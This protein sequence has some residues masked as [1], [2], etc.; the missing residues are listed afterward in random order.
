[1]NLRNRFHNPRILISLGSILTTMAIFTNQFLGKTHGVP[2]NWAH[3]LAGFL[4]GMAI[5]FSL[6]GVRLKKHR[7]AALSCGSQNELP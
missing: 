4:L 7:G 2:H 5:V 1:M 6:C 3:A